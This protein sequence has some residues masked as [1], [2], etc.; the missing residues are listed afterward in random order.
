M[1]M[2]AARMS[3]LLGSTSY[4]MPVVDHRGRPATTELAGHAF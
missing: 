4:L 3:S 1:D 2:N